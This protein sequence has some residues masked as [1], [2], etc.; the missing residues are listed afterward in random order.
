M[1][2]STIKRD[3]S[4]PLD[5]NAPLITQRDGSKATLASVAK[6]RQRSKSL[7]RACSDTNVSLCRATGDFFRE[8]GLPGSRFVGPEDMNI[9]D[10]I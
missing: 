8:W 10:Y 9:E 7:I 2:Q 4:Q 1:Q 5:L 6:A 3:P